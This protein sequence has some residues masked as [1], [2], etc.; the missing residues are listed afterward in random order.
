MNANR[1]YGK[2][3]ENYGKVVSLIQHQEENISKGDDVAQG[4]HEDIDSIHF[5]QPSI[6]EH[7][8]RGFYSKNGGN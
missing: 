1:K 5:Q 6:N 3:G 4:T 2:H 8:A 7:I